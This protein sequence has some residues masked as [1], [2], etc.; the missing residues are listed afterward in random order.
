MANWPVSLTQDDVRLQPLRLRDRSR[1]EQL[2][3]RNRDWLAPW[4]ATTPRPGAERAASFPEMVRRQRQQGFA[5]QSLPWALWVADTLIGQVTVSGIVGGAAR[6]CNIGY[7]ID[8][9]HAG[10]GFMPRAVAMATRYA[11]ER[12]DLH[13]VEIA[14]RPENHASLRVVAKLGFAYEGHRPAFLHIAGAWRDHDIFTVTS[15]ALADPGH[16]VNRY[17]AATVS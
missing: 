4:E 12:L 6:L 8:Q 5:G 1:W 3:A 9:S 7:W 15:E 10:R 11:V 17:P 2:R 16:P 13:R 14:I